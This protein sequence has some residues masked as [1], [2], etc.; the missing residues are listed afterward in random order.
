M[1]CN[2]GAN[3]VSHLLLLGETMMKEGDWCPF[4]FPGIEMSLSKNRCGIRNSKICDKLTFQ[5]KMEDVTGS[6]TRLDRIL[7]V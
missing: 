5:L 2:K 4:P 7:T 3:T 1:V 6:V